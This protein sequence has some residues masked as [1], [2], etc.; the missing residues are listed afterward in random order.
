LLEASVALLI[1]PCSAT[2]VGAA[3]CPTTEIALSVEIPVTPLGSTAI[4]SAIFP[5]VFCTVFWFAE[6]SSAFAGFF[7]ETPSVTFSAVCVPL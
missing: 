3:T 1:S 4:A 2:A 5:T 6:L 7:K